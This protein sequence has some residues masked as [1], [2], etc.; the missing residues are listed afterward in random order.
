MF[1]GR[2]K[3]A[4]LAAH[5]YLNAVEQCDIKNEGKMPFLSWSYFLW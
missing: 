1:D 3:E 2:L 5:N 4:K